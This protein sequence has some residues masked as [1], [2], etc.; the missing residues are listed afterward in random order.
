M[1]INNTVPIISRR[2]WLYVKNKQWKCTGFHL[3]AIE[4]EKKACRVESATSPDVRLVY[5]KW[6][7]AVL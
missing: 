2:M 7:Y 3:S 1:I 4:Q 5:V 6:S